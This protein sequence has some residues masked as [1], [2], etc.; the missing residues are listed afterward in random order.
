M[1]PQDKD[2]AFRLTLMTKIMKAIEKD[3]E[4]GI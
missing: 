4:R 1:C 2:L 3:K